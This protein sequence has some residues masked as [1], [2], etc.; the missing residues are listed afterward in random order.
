[1]N[2]HTVAIVHNVPSAGKGDGEKASQDVLSQVAAVDM[3]LRDLGYETR[4]LPFTRDVAALCEHFRKGGVDRIVNLCETVD[5]DAQL[6][7]HPAALFELLHVPFSGSPS[8]ALMVT[9]DKIMTKRLLRS[10]GI[11][12]P[13]CLLYNGKGYFSAASLAFPVIL[14][15]RHEDASIGI[16]Q[17]SVV[18]GER[19]LTERLQS[20]HNTYGEII[21]EE[22]IQG[23]E[24]NVSLL[25]YPVPCVMPIA[26]IDFSAFPKGMHHIVGYKAKWDEHSFEYNHTPRRFDCDIDPLLRAEI[27]RISLLCFSYFG[28][29][30]YGRIDMRVD[31]HKRIYIV[32]INA[33]PCISPDAGFPASLAQ[34]NISYSEMMRSFMHYMDIR[35]EYEDTKGPIERPGKHN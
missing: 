4:R 25:G 22:Y 16:D 28:L 20:M 31:R 9:T 5:E 14:K 30:D 10:K 11:R 15:P 18:E 12:T 13:E 23:R 2:K 21:V 32:E 7:G 8:L 34:G 24:F 29:R 17:E 3:T 33:N 27:K 6:A 26:E 35:V 19:D 1:M